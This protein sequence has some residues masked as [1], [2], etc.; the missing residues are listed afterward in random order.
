MEIVVS[1]GM[2]PVVGTNRVEQELCSLC[3]PPLA[4][5]IDKLEEEAF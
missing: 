3:E 4:K 2:P 1:L 5:E